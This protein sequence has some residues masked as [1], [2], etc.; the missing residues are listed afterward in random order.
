MHFAGTS[1]AVPAGID[2]EPIVDDAM[3]SRW[4]EGLMPSAEARRAL[5]GLPRPVRAK[6]LTILQ[7]KT[8]QT[9]ITNPSQYLLGII[10]R[11]GS[12]GPYTAPARPAISPQAAAV[13]PLTACAPAVPQSVPPTN[14]QHR[15]PWVDAAWPLISKPGQLIRKLG[16]V[17]DAASIQ[18]LINFPAEVQMAML[19]SLLLSAS[20]WEKPGAHLR[21]M[22]A[23]GASLPAPAAFPAANQDVPTARPLVVVQL[24]P[25][26]GVEW[27]LLD[28][29]VQT[30]Q[31]DGVGFTVADR[32]ACVGSFPWAGTLKKDVA[33]MSGPPVAVHFTAGA[34]T[35]HL[36]QR[37]ASWHACDA[38]FL[39]LLTFPHADDK[40][41]GPVAFPGMHCEP[42]NLIYSALRV[43]RS[44]ETARPSRY[45][46]LVFEPAW[47]GARADTMGAHLFGEG[48]PLMQVL[49]KV[50]CAPW[51]WHAWP[52]LHNAMAARKVEQLSNSSL[53]HRDLA[54][55]AFGQESGFAL[56]TFAELEQWWDAG[57]FPNL[58]LGAAKEEPRSLHALRMMPSGSSTLGTRL[59]TTVEL[60]ELWGL[61][62]WQWTTAWLQACG[63]QGFIS[64]VTGMAVPPGSNPAGAVQCGTCRYCS[65]CSQ[66]YQALMECPPPH[67]W[68]VLP[69]LLKKG[70]D[71]AEPL[72]RPNPTTWAALCEHLCN[73]FGCGCC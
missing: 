13:V 33:S 23:V 22:A 57:N 50:P 59:L 52:R 30:L 3:L 19:V 15:P 29:A 24:G 43:T 2:A 26:T 32:I 67:A 47:C 41:D 53:Y 60:A 36:T 65:S 16:T 21:A 12:C 64:K 18:T 66:F 68:S 51:R 14:A 31:Q 5:M 34:L 58:G 46:E 37:S 6:L 1:A 20:S 42:A 27:L 62:G 73:G 10:R 49:T 11:E 35:E 72:V 55:V 63:C 25:S 8:A 56:P 28:A 70:L 40:R 17:V 7:A 39:V 9:T 71:I 48:A 69:E 45:H 4:F 61:G 44:L 38:T 54:R